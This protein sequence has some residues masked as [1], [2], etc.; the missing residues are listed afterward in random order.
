[1]Q[2]P[3]G[4]GR[5][6]EAADELLI[7]RRRCGNQWRNAGNARILPGTADTAEGVESWR[8]GEPATERNTRFSLCLRGR[9]R[10]LTRRAYGATLYGR[11]AQD[12]G[13]LTASELDGRRSGSEP[14]AVFF[15]ATPHQ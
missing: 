7:R 4:M 2:P 5:V 6:A 1:M 12:M 14:D 8:D 15:L 11:Q 9:G 13:P 10:E 3:K